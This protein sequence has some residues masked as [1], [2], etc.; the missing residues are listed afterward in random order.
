M[1]RGTT[2]DGFMYHEHG[3]ENSMTQE[4]NQA[5]ELVREWHQFVE[6]ECTKRYAF[7]KSC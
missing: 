4:E 7:T 5:A 1:R 6:T 3:R 2:L